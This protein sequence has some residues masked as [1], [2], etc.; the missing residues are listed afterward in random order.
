MRSHQLLNP[1]LQLL[2]QLHRRQLLLQMPCQQLRPLLQHSQLLRL[3]RSQIQMF[4]HNLH[5]LHNL[6]S[7]QLQ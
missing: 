5:N 6:Q 4:P 1:N 7:L 2:P 3:S